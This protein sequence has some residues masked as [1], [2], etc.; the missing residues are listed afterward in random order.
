MDEAESYGSA[1]QESVSDETHQRHGAEAG[2]A[3]SVLKWGRR[4]QAIAVLQTVRG[5]RRRAALLLPRRDPS[6]AVWASPV[7][8][9]VP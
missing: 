5:G 3:P 7:A 1:R 2:A 4:L 9:P 6:P 8:A